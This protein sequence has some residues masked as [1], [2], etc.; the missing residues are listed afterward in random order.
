MAPKSDRLLVGEIQLSP[1]DSAAADMGTKSR[2]SKHRLSDMLKKTEK[3]EMWIMC[4]RRSLPCR[5]SEPEFEADILVVSRTFRSSARRLELPS[6]LY[7]VPN[8]SARVCLR[9]EGGGLQLSVGETNPSEL[10]IYIV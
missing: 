5:T 9:W 6:Y 3:A 10:G 2:K 1:S 4:V 7:R 8:R